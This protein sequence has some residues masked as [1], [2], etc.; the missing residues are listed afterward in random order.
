MLASRKAYSNSAFAFTSWARRYEAF[1]TSLNRA[2]IIDIDSGVCASLISCIVLMMPNSGNGYRFCIK[3]EYELIAL[4]KANCLRL[5]DR[6]TAR[7]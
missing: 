5:T 2:A 6:L 4:S 7:S 3:L 1:V